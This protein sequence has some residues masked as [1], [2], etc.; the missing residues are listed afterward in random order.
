M[1]AKR[2]KEKN[3]EKRRKKKK[4]GGACGVHFAPSLSKA[5]EREREEKS[6]LGEGGKKRGGGRDSPGRPSRLTLLR[7][8]VLHHLC[9]GG[10]KRKERKGK[11]KKEKV[12][13]SLRSG[14]GCL[15]EKK[16]GVV[17]AH[18]R[19]VRLETLLDTRV[20]GS[21]KRKRG[22]RKEKKRARHRASDVHCI[23]LHA[24]QPEGGE[25]EKEEKYLRKGGRKGG[26]GRGFSCLSTS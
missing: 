9:R 1:P 22:K 25:G 16:G 17:I 4:K 6:F 18:H 21:R 13:R 19:L 12:P 20:S 15:Q 8:I 3:G 11:R 14:E 24:V 2:E 23:P 10:E 5:S 26:R 7:I